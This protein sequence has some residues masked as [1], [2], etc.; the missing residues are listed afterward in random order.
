MTIFLCKQI[1]D[2]F[3]KCQKIWANIFLFL[4]IQILWRKAQ[5]ISRILIDSL[6]EI[7]FPQCLSKQTISADSVSYFVYFLFGWILIVVFDWI[8]SSESLWVVNYKG[9]NAVL[10]SRSKRSI[11]IIYILLCFSYPT[12][13]LLRNTR[14]L[15]IVQ[16]PRRSLVKCIVWTHH[17]TPFVY[18]LSKDCSA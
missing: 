4:Q 8:W 3:S 16:S 15:R 9:M 18:S 13:L 5:I 12:S 2:S 7:E 10:W 11:D 1:S 6:W 17:A 14:L